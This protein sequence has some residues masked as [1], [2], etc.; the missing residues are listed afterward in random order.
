MKQIEIYRN[1]NGDTRSGEV[2]GIEISPEI[3]KKAM[4]NTVKMVD[5]ITVVK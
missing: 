4:D 2:R 5:N 3:L 1:P